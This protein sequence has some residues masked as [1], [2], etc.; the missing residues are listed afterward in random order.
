[1]RTSLA[2][3][4]SLSEVQQFFF[5][6]FPGPHISGHAKNSIIGGSTTGR[7]GKIITRLRFSDNFFTIFDPKK[8][9]PVLLVPNCFN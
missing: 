1:M 3:H 9:S 5:H 2:Q 8:F 6:V 7:Y 4:A